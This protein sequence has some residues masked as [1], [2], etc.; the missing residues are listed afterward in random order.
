MKDLNKQSDKVLVSVVMP[1]LNEVETIGKCIKKAKMALRKYPYE[2]IVCDNGSTDGSHGVAKKSGARVIVEERKGYGQAY[3]TGLNIARGKFILIGDSDDTYDFRESDKFIKKLIE[4]YDFV[5]GSRMK[6]RILP[7][8]MSFTHRYIG[9]L[10]LSFLLNLF[11]RTN[12]S[13]SYCGMKAFTKD[14]YKKIKP[15]SKGM[16]FALELMVNT[17]KEKFNK[18]EIPIT[19]YPRKG[20]SKLRTLQDGWQSLRFLLLLSP[21]YLF[22]IP[23]LVCLL[24]GI[25]IVI[26]ILPE[27][28]PF[29]G[30]NWDYHFMFVGSVLAIL[31]FQILV[32]G[33]FAKSLMLYLNLQSRTSWVG[34][35][36]QNFTLEK[37]VIIGLFTFLIGFLI[38]IRILIIWLKAGLG[39]IYEIRPAIF[40]LTLMVIGAQ[41][42]FSSF[43]LRVLSDLNQETS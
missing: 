8:S 40:A 26:A 6:G 37:G 17:A 1:C 25:A 11:F 33:I 15:K 13:D 41:A 14:V 36:S 23:G 42:I 38:N 7:G 18:T 19:Y 21:D 24:L 2:I 4:G 5:N 10:T 43:F 9:N 27:P 32:V 3:L 31:G 22:I 30:H 29:V 35:F 20:A 39:P 28:V 34:K 16:E 12:F